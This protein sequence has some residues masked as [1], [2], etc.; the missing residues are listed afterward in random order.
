MALN[1]FPEVLDDARGVVA[2]AET[3]INSAINYASSYAT[4]SD[5]NIPFAV[6]QVPDIAG[7]VPSS[8]WTFYNP[9][10]FTDT[11]TLRDIVVPD[12]VVVPEAP[13]EIDDSNL[14]NIEKPV[15]DIDTTGLEAPEIV[16]PDLPTAVAIDNAIYVPPVTSTLVAPTI[17]TPSFDVDFEGTTPTSP[18]STFSSDYETRLPEIQASMES[19]AE[20]FI[21]TYNPSYHN[22]LTTLESKLATAI[23]GNTAIDDAVEEQIFNRSV[24]R[25]LDERFA[26]EK[27][28]TESLSRRGYSAPP[29]LLA[30]LVKEAVA[31]HARAVSMGA[32]ETAINRA[33]IEVQHLQ[34]CLNVSVSIRQAMVSAVLQAQNNSLQAGQLAISYAR[35]VSQFAVAIFNAQVSMFQAQ[36]AV[37]KAKADVYQ[38]RVEAAFAEIRKFE[39]RI[40]AEK[41]KID[42]D[43]NAIALYQSR[44]DAQQAKI[45]LYLGQLQGVQAVAEFQRLNLEGYKAKIQGFAAR[46]GAKEAEFGAYR[47]SIEG[48][49]AKVGV[50]SEKL[51][52]YEARIRASNT[53]IEG[54]RIQSDVITQNNRTLIERYNANLEAHK[55]ALLSAGKEFDSGEALTKAALDAYLAG[56]RGRESESNLELQAKEQGLKHVI[57]GAEIN[58]RR[59]IASAEMFQ[60][61]NNTAADVAMAGAGAYASM[62]S[63]AMSVVNNIATKDFTE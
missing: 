36:T 6:Y 11:V 38:I 20:S 28:V 9:P 24:S 32:S 37:F 15:F 58:T 12:D 4:L 5:T 7:T 46:V 50:Y 62:A 31:N 43:R 3:L 45:Q 42:L 44:I 35:E 57:S 13:E 60:S 59:A 53:V 2:E 1:S 18:T 29:G 21:S 56:L 8:K 23:T 30:K 51:R 63:A 55:A 14:F 19:A 10:S 33:Q 25:A 27:Q 34:F 17:V 41:L 54:Q 22:A 49:I 39:A 47:S 16:T 61:R 40:E 52:G 26:V 48:D